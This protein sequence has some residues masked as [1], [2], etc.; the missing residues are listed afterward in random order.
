MTF[1]FPR[2]S[3]LRVLAMPLLLGATLLTSHATHPEKQAVTHTAFRPGQPWLDTHG[4][5]INAHGF[6]VLDVDGR[7]HWYG[8][9]KI[10][11]KTEDEKNEAGV[12][13]YVS[14]DLLNWQ[15]KGLVLS[16]F[17]PGAHPELAEA[18]I[19]DRP[20]VVFNAATRKFVLYFKLYPP[21]EKGGE[22]G[23]DY[24]WVGVATSSTP[25]GPFDYQGYFLGNHSEFGTGDFAIFT[26]TDGAIYHVAVRKPDKA[27]VYGR[28]SADGLK[29]EGEYKVL[30]GVTPKTEAPAFFRRG[31]KVYLLASGTSGWK[32][33]PARMFVADTFTGP[34]AELPNPCVGVNPRNNLGPDK[35]FGGQSTFVYAVP[36]RKDAWI[37]M[38]D[39]NKPEDPVNSGYIWLP[40]EFEGGRPVIR[41]RDQWDLSVFPKEEG[42]KDARSAFGRLRPPRT[43]ALRRLFKTTRARSAPAGSAPAP[44]FADSRR[45]SPASSA[46]RTRRFC[47]CPAGSWSSED[48]LAPLVAHRRSRS[49]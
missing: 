13:L 43:R 12:R 10:A 9:E 17:A 15:D 24:A 6:A 22:S 33:N 40:V 21:R 30:E 4:V 20:K 41:W 11:G 14:D 48:W 3:G 37:A 5:P 34:Y 31:E 49:W 44:A 38:F 29:P 36:G 23:K 39:I 26:D 46:R 16:V 28:L 7:H 19:L 32:P 2:P 47:P 18:F 42:P 1:S 25:A 35:T 27:L 8:A 45:R